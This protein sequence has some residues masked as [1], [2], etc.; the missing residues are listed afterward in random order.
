MKQLHNLNHLLVNTMEFAWCHLLLGMI[1]YIT[2][3]HFNEFFLVLITLVI[4]TLTSCYL[5]HCDS[6][7]DYLAY[8]I[9]HKHVVN[10]LGF[11]F[12]FVCT[13]VSLMIIY[14]RGYPCVHQGPY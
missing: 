8:I 2:T 1:T 12:L 6:D 10:I 13:L 9:T 4:V 14:Q 11:S 7:T 5:S 3:L